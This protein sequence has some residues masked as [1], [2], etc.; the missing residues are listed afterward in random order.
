MKQLIFL[1][2]KTMNKNYRNKLLLPIHFISYGYIPAKMYHYKE[3]KDTLIAIDNNH[4]SRKWGND[5]VFG[6]VFL[7]D[8]YNVTIRTLD[9]L[10]ACSK[11]R[12]NNNNKN[13]LMHRVKTSVT[14][15]TFN[16]LEELTVM[17][18]KEREQVLADTYLGNP[19]H[20]W[21]KHRIKMQRYRVI[22]G[23][24]KVHFKKMFEQEGVN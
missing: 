2:D 17:K 8:Y 9:G 19:N 24:D 23:I 5:K 3:H 20:E 14:L 10:Y 7:L 1:Y 18:Y 21:I 13:D 22:D 4:V 12:L 15:I 16:D 11:A 6:G